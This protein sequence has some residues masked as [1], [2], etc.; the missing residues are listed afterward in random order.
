MCERSR[1]R[2]PEVELAPAV[3]WPAP[4]A[5]RSTLIS[6]VSLTIADTCSAVA[7]NVAIACVFVI[8]GYSYEGLGSTAELMAFSSEFLAHRLRDSP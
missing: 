2:P 4:E 8:R 3:L 7:G 6:W 5:A 1:A